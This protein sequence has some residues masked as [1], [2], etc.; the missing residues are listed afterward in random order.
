MPFGRGESLMIGRLQGTLLEVDADRVL[1]DTGGVGYEVLVPKSVLSGLPPR[2]ETVVLFIR[3]IW[4][5]DGP[6]L[7]GFVDGWE[8]KLFDLLVSVSGVGPK[9]A[10]S[11]IGTLGSDT[12]AQSIAL[13]DAKRL[14]TV[15]GVGGKTAQRIV[16][17]LGDKLA[18]AAFER[19]LETVGVSRAGSEVVIDAIE[20]LIVMGFRRQEAGNA[21]DEAIKELGKDVAVDAVVKEALK[22][23]RTKG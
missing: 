3:L 1:V 11:L 6:S 17:E 10:L 20:A 15:S 8:R 19:R 16:L 14:Q 9:V 21:V 22:R 7:Y 18:V 5:E 12:L 2:N 13:G 23:V 4:R